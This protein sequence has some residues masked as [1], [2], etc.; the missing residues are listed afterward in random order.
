MSILIIYTIDNNSTQGYGSGNFKVS[1]SP[2]SPS[3]KT[4]TYKNLVCTRMGPKKYNDFEYY[5]VDVR[6]VLNDGQYDTQYFVNARFDPNTLQVYTTFNNYTTCVFS[7]TETE[8][9]TKF[10]SSGVTGTINQMNET[11][12]NVTTNDNSS[13]LFILNQIANGTTTNLSVQNTSSPNIGFTT[14]GPILCQAYVAT[15]VLNPVDGPTL[16]DA[17]G[18][19]IAG[20]K[21]K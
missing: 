1:G 16:V 6:F 3:E 18:I 9:S 5:D 17:I 11:S 21:Y 15:L 4:Y 8:N 13:Q 14:G 10:S 2:I 12:N 20:Y 7:P 19:G